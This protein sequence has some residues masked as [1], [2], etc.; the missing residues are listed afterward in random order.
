MNWERLISEQKLDVLINRL[1]NTNDP[2]EVR[3]LYRQWS[4]SYDADLGEHGYVAPQIGVTLFQQ[5]IRDLSISNADAL[6]HDAGCGTG[7]VGQLLNGLGF[8]NIE[9]SDFSQDMLDLAQQKN[10]YHNLLQA[11]YT[12]PIEITTGRYDGVISIGV[13][14]KRFKR[15]FV[16]EMLRIL[17]PGGYLLFSCRPVYF[18]EVADTVK[19]LH[20]DGELLKSSVHFDD[21]MIAQKASAYYVAIQK[22]RDLHD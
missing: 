3:R 10:C 14:T 8:Q 15:R 22:Q 16:R 19:N 7:L 13:Y 6:V 20:V 11:D 21:Y 1:V 18:E 17:K 4:A 9:G 5:L 12:Q 2:E